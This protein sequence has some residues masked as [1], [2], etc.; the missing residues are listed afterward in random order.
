MRLVRRLTLYFLLAIGVIFAFDSYLS[1]VQ[2]LALFDADLRRDERLMGR[3]LGRAV[4]RAWAEQ[5]ESHAL[6]L[7]REANDREGEVSIRLVFLDATPGTSLAAGAPVDA[8]EALRRERAV[9]QVRDEERIYTYVPLAIA[10]PRAAALELS[11]S[12]RHERA[13]LLARIPRELS[14]AT[15]MVMACGLVAWVVGIRVVGRPIRALVEKARRIGAGDFST[16]LVLRQRD[17]LS[18]LA[19]EMNTMAEHLDSATRKVSA[20]SAARIAALEQLRHADRLTTVGKLAAGLA[21]ELGTPLNVVSGRARMILEGE[22]VGVPD[23]A[24]SA[25]I[26]VDQAERMTRIVRQLLDFARRRSP[27]K[28]STEVVQLARQ[29]SSLLEPLAARRGV[30]LRCEPQPAPLVALVDPSQVQ[31]ALTNLV[32]NAIQATQ[33]GGHVWIRIDGQELAGSP[34]DGQRSGAYAVL[35]VEDDGEGIPAD[36]LPAIFDPFFTTKAVGEGTG[37]GLA[38]AHGIVQEH[39]G[40]IDVRSEP[41]R[42]SCFRIWLPREVERDDP[43]ADRP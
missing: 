37:L 26:I 2:H 25:Q 8:L 33:R 28:R 4:E 15:L 20:E 39:G 6:E 29:T 3:A 21:H 18:L 43:G 5:G 42:G 1:L 16:P 30:E 19:D 36:R 31:Q 38:V 32:V 23:T 24:K 27:E 12:L 9:S 13:Y 10:G 7:V 35:A 14:T 17:E 34:A 40:W 41:G 11:E 22:T